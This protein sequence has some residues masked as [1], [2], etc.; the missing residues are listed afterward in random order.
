VP[1]DLM[2]GVAKEIRAHLDG[3]KPAGKKVA[4]QGESGK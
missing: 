2:S 3:K 4:G 1:N